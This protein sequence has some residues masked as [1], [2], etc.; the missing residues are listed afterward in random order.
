MVAVPIMITI[1]VTAAMLLR[2]SRRH[3]A[4]APALFLSVAPSRRVAAVIRVAV[5]RAVIA[6]A[7]VIAIC[8]PV[9]AVTIFVAIFVTVSVAVMVAV[10]AVSIAAIL[11]II[12]IAASMAMI[13]CQSA[14]REQSDS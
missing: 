1:A 12:V 5:M 4:I 2:L 9:V 6:V 14:C 13:F 8:S 10:I 11:L 7:V 3:I